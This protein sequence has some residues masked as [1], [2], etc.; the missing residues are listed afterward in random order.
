MN[1]PELETQVAR[2]LELT[3]YP[4]PEWVRARRHQGEPVVDVLIVG[5]GQAG[6]TLAFALK[7]RA[8][9]N[10]RILEAA[11]AGSEGP[12]TT[13]AAMHTLRTPKTLT[14]PD[15]GLPALTPEAWYRAA[16]GDAAWEALTHIPKEHWQDY[17]GW[18]R[19]VTAPDVRNGVEVHAIEPAGDG[20]LEVRHTGGTTYARRVVLAT[21]LAG[22]GQ[23]GVPR[24]I[25]DHLPSERYIHT[26]ARTDFSRFAGQRVGVLGGGAS[27]FD[28]A[29]SAL[30]HGAAS[31]DLFYRRHEVPRVNPFRWMEF[32][33]FG[34]H[35]PDLPDED[36]WKFTVQFQRINQPPP[37][38]TWYRCTSH[39]TF[40]WHTGADWKGVRLDGPGPDADIVVDSGAGQFRFD[41]L[42][43]GIGPT[44]D[45]ASRP[46]LSAL[47]PHAA[48]WS[49]RFTPPADWEDPALLG[50]PYLDGD[51]GFTEARP[52]TA[53]WLSRV[54][55]FT[56]GARLSMGLNGNMN[57]GLGAGGR[58][59]AEALS[60]SLFLEDRAQFFDAYQAFD[61]PELVDLGRP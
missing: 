25:S 27:A 23:W 30:E 24:L 14:G 57:S 60:R 3:A 35:F 44:V 28:Y 42:I 12:W 11:P 8:I 48:R 4:R 6:L 56:Y 41:A 10:T 15:Q 40:A 47:A 22:N 9:T 34:A 46:E 7:R 19:A 16:H 1:L 53:P 32:Y 18:F 26:G 33:A 59:L 29:A 58:R 54:H 5:G 2:Q 51:F 20:V 49:D 55:D 50:Y 43:S 17:L 37:Q 36:K 31:V 13:Y 45:L 21:G 52:G 61:V 39:D 38:Q